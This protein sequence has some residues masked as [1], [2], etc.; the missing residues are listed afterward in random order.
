MRTSARKALASALTVVTVGCADSTTQPLQSDFDVR[1]ALLD[2][3][4]LDQV[5]RSDA[6][7][8]LETLGRR[9]SGEDLL[10]DPGKG[11]PASVPIISEQA[12]R[13]TFVYDPETDGY[14][15]D[16]ARAGAPPNGVRF[17]LYAADVTGRPDVTAETGH[18]D[19]LDMGDALPGSLSLRFVVTVEGNQRMD[20]TVTAG[21]SERAGA[22]GV[23]GFLRGERDLLAFNIVA[24]GRRD[25]EN[26]ASEARFV[27]SMD[28]R[29]FR[30]TA[31]QTGTNGPGGGAGGLE[32]AVQHGQ[33]SITV[34]LSGSESA[35]SGVFSVNGRVLASVSG[36]PE[37]PAFL[38][39]G[40]EP[41]DP[42]ELRAL[43]HV[44]RLQGQVFHLF[45]T[46][47][48]PAA[49]LIALGIGL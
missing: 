25:G 30:A 18:A 15:R 3:A 23:A 1:A 34:E 43:G 47:M 42:D 22:V 33:Q 46:L 4:A 2:Y 8:Q 12:R 40:G 32:L 20:Y 36:L 35:V 28:E 19:L 37:S 10:A 45:Q 48:E 16:A 9:I 39:A 27:V 49:D 7:V 6:L 31:T 38:G 13:S 21:G 5:L 26:E 17:I 44:M 11:G 41:L 29:G 14:R 24:Q